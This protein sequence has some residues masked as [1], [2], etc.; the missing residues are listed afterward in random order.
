M[1]RQLWNAY[2]AFA[3][4]AVSPLESLLTFFGDEVREHI[5]ARKCPF[6]NTPTEPSDNRRPSA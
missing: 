1:S 2:C 4:G 5:T 6:G 3:P